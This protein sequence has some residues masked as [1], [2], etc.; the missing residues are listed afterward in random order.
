MTQVSVRAIA[1]VHAGG[2]GVSANSSIG[3]F[4]ADLVG[5]MRVQ[6][7]YHH[8]PSAVIHSVYVSLGQSGRLPATSIS[9]DVACRACDFATNSSQLVVTAVF[10]KHAIPRGVCTSDERLKVRKARL[11]INA[12]SWLIT[13]GKG[14]VLTDYGF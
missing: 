11:P 12:S 13:T 5:P 2:N 1:G 8:C 7:H 14:C 6:R 3:V 9:N 4:V 10:V